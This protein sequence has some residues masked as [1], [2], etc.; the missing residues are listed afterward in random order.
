VSVSGTASWYCCTYGYGN[1]LFAAA[2]PSLR[3]F[4]GPGWRGKIIET[5]LSN[6]PARCI[7]VKLVDWMANPDALIDL[8][9]AAFSQLARL[10]AGLVRVRVWA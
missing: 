2:G 10:S 4:L 5:C 7:R 6:E 8:E 1:G 9:P 3:R